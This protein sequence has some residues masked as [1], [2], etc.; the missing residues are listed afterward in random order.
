MCCV[1]EQSKI[2]LYALLSELWVDATW[3]VDTVSANSI[4]D[5]ISQICPLLLLLVL[6]SKKSKI[7]Q[8]QITDNT[9]K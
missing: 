6:Q 4:Y 2:D 8:N 9:I 1:I 3:F 7:G 5:Q